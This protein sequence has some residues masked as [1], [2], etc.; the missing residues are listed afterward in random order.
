MGERQ[1]SVF[2]PERDQ[3]P[4]FA[5]QNVG[6]RRPGQHDD[7]NTMPTAPTQ[8]LR[9]VQRQI[10]SPPS[11]TAINP[12][13]GMRGSVV[14]EAGQLATV[15]AMAVTASTPQPIGISATEANP[16]GIRSTARTA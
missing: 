7:T 10:Q 11:V 1:S 3:F 5:D 6:P 2:E 13:V 15:A 9:P 14:T 4:A 16:K 12:P 8:R